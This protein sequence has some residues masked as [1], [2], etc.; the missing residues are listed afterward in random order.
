MKTQEDKLSNG[1][2]YVDLGRNIKAELYI[3]GDAKEV[4]KILTSL[5]QQGYK[6]IESVCRSFGRKVVVLT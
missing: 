3:K 1:K 5:Q 4:I 6:T 2:G